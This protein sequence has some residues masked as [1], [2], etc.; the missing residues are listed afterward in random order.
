M[1]K[2]ITIKKKIIN[3]SENVM[4]DICELFAHN[5]FQL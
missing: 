1:G 4:N 5:G 2:N 3:F